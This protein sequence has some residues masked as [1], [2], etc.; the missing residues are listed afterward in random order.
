M[1]LRVSRRV[2]KDSR[3][4][5][6]ALLVLL[7]IADFADDSGLAWP[8]MTALVHKA[9]VPE[10]TM[11]RVLAALEASGEV[12]VQRRVGRGK[13]NHYLVATGQ[14]KGATLTPFPASQKDAHMAPFTDTRK[15]AISHRK[16]AISTE[17]VPHVAPGTVNRTINR[18]V[19]GYARVRARDN[20]SKNSS[21]ETRKWPR[22]WDPAEIDDEG[23]EDA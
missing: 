13:T 15:G 8:S 6:R 19:R 11:H 9:R 12:V 16:G 7:A 20:H 5:G 23:G 4:R 22:G 18:T 21:V 17:K 10:R 3:H 14:G 2:W 1:S